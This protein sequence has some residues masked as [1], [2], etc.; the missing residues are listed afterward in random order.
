M[1]NEQA[2]L[3]KLTEELEKLS[4]KRNFE[5]GEFIYLLGDPSDSVYLV[6]RGHVKLFTVSET[7]RKLTLS[8]LGQGDLFG[9]ES[10]TGEKSRRL[11]AEVFE[12]S[13]VCIIEKTDV[14]N[15][16]SRDPQLPLKLMG[17][18][19]QRLR[20]IQ[21]KLEDLLF[22]DTEARLSCVLLKLA[23]QYGKK[24]GRSIEINFRI[25]H[26]ELAD[27]VGS[28]RESVTAMLNRFE[29]EGI[30]EKNRYSITIKDK[31][32]LEHKTNFR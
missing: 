32:K 7:G 20:Q 5:K 26:Q 29:R 23:K 18:W 8:L 22:K 30:L 25:T 11:T 24:Q 13:T 1:E 28:A 6:K 9:E 10:L 19:G 12:D 15:L 31:A 21:E 4:H 17:F 2:E 3:R 16:I 14:L 27:L